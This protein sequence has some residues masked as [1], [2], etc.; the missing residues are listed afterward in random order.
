MQHLLTKEDLSVYYFLKDLFSST[1]MV[2]VIKSFPDSKVGI[3]LPIIAVEHDRLTG[4]KFEM[5]SRISQL[6]RD[7][8]IDIFAMTETQRDEISYKIVEELDSTIPVYDYDEG[9]PPDVSPSLIG[10]LEVLSFN[11]DVI[12]ISPELLDENESMYY[13]A[14]VTFTAERNTR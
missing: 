5:G 7:Y 13:R 14:V 11:M 4:A 6:T 10:G 2:N 12:R 1:N 9:F 8:I 3:K